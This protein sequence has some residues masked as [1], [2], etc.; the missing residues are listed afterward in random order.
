MWLVLMMVCGGMELQSEGNPQPPPAPPAAVDVERFNVSTGPMKVVIA[1]VTLRDEARGK[2]LELRVRIPSPAGS[3]SDAGAR[4]M[5]IF[6]HGAGGSRE[7]FGGMLDLWASHGFASIAPTHAD[8]IEL[9]RRSGAEPQ[10]PLT[11]KEGRRQ[12]LGKVNLADRVADCRFI[13]DHLNDICSAASSGREVTLKIDAE[14]VAIAGHSAGAFTAQLCAGVKARG[15]GLGRAGAGFISIGDDRFK[16]AII[17]SGQGTMSRLLGGDSWADVRIPMFVITG[18]LDGSPP[19]MGRET[20]ESR[21]HPFTRSRGVKSGGPPAY[22][23]FIQGATHSSYQGKNLADLLGE[24]PA[25]D[26]T[27]IAEAVD[28]ATTVFLK[29]HLNGQA[30]ALELLK[31]KRLGDTIP[32]KVIYSSK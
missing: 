14:K 25:V 16:A 19:D 4:P 27:L 1:D 30:D 15:A 32:G 26:V 8:S 13:L 5:V 7:A 28:S 3:E 22:L 20:P 6:S 21:Q 12:L 11:T 24:K 18:S 10:L 9:R 29:A 23:L 31:G 2:D 17:I